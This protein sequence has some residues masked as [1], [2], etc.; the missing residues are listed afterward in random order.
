MN[1]ITLF[2]LILQ[3]NMANGQATKLDSLILSMHKSLLSVSYGPF[4]INPEDNY[5]DEGYVW[6]YEYRLVV[7]AWE[8]YDQL[9]VE[10]LSY[11]DEEGFERK[12]TDIGYVSLTSLFP[13]VSQ[14]EQRNI[15]S[16]TW[17]DSVTAE[18]DINHK[19]FT[20]KVTDYLNLE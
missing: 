9:Y 11:L 10:R 5:R 1:V 7:T 2:T 16:I 3:I 20:I 17:L 12:I 6:G 4:I 15:N 13:E 8:T 18:I 14:G 19:K